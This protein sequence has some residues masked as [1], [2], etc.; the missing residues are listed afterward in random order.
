MNPE[1]RSV[2]RALLTEERLVAL[3]LPDF[4]LYRLE[5]RGGRL[6]LGFGQALNLSRDH[7][8]D[9]ARA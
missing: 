1:D 7:F 8:R 5:I 3:A 4:S 6:I 2:L 9:L